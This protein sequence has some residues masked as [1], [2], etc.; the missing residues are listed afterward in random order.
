MLLSLLATTRALAAPAKSCRI[1][2]ERGAFD[3]GCLPA[4]SARGTLVAVAAI[5]PGRPNLQVNFFR[6][7]GG[8][9]ASTT[10]LTVAEVDEVGGGQLSPELVEKIE[11]RLDLVNAQLAFAGFAALKAD[12]ELQA[13]VKDGRLEVRG[14][15]F[16]TEK[17][18]L[19]SPPPGCA[20]A[21]PAVGGAWSGAGAG[22]V[23]VR[24]DF[25]CREARPAW[26]VLHVKKDGGQAEQASAL[27]TRGMRK[28]R[29]K[30]WAGAAADFRAAIDL[31]PGHVKAHYNL[32]CV[33]SMARDR[34]TAL[35]QLRWLAASDLPEAAEKIV[36]ARTDPDLA[37][38]RGDPEGLR[39]LAD[40][41][42]AARR[43]RP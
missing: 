38:I 27:N 3:V 7:D 31:F 34:A 23:V 19:P 21:S 28:F 37:F 30:D 40:H 35:E 29:A 17:V 12:K 1:A 4:L 8:A 18:P 42:A 20:G 6:V 24:I 41:D 15:R 16:E 2:L 43:S 26:R 22:E 36:K 11:S 33:A 14:A 25:A 39:A 32:A 5:A 13:S 10:V 9:P